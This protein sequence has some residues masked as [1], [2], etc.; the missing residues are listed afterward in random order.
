MIALA[1]VT[2]DLR[3]RLR[4]VLGA[5]HDALGRPSLKAQAKQPTMGDS[6]VMR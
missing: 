2:R 5:L 4:T 3:Q 6:A 1:L